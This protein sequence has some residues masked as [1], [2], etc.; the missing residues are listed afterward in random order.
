MSA[1]NPHQGKAS[2]PIT[3]YLSFNG[4]LGKLSN[5][6]GDDPLVDVPFPVRMLPLDLDHFMAENSDMQGTRRKVTSNMGHRQ[7]KPVLTIKFDK[8]NPDEQPI[9]V[10]QWPAGLAETPVLKA[11]GVHYTNVMFHSYTNPVTKKAELTRLKLHGKAA[12]AYSDARKKAVA[13]GEAIRSAANAA[14]IAAGKPEDVN[15]MMTSQYDFVY[16]IT[17]VVLTESTKG[18]KSYVPVFAWEPLSAKGK[19]TQIA[20]DE[21]LQKLIKDYYGYVEPVEEDVDVSTEA[22]PLVQSAPPPAAQPAPIQQAAPAPVQQPAPPPAA[23][24][25]VTPPPPVT[26]DQLPF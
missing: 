16:S 7:F 20:Q 11:W 5:K 3:N 22:P 9:Y 24:P 8:P 17:G 23:P 2:L 18:P 6:P 1:S 13:E 15:E 10:G 14:A 12:W 26:D 19:E 25:V 21:E 4:L